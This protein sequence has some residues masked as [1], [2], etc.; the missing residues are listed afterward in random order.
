MSTNRRVAVSAALANAAVG[1]KKRNSVVQ[2]NEAIVAKVREIGVAAYAANGGGKKKGGDAIGSDDLESSDYDDDSSLES[3]RRWKKKRD[4][5]S[6]GRSR[7]RSRSRSRGRSYSRSRWEMD[8]GDVSIST[9]T[10]EPRTCSP[11]YKRDKDKS[12]ENNE[13]VRLSIG[14]QLTIES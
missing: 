7:S 2:G 11:P 5:R 14:S 9:I 6:R 3:L 8:Y 1:N 4:R 12:H 10:G 13:M